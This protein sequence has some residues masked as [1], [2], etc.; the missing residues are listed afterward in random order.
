ML[1]TRATDAKKRI[2]KDKAAQMQTVSFI[3]Y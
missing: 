2:I 1:V 3:I